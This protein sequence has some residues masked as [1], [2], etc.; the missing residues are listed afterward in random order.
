MSE[1]S[2]EKTILTPELMFNRIRVIKEIWSFLPS[3]CYR[4]KKAD[5]QRIPAQ[6]KQPN[7][8]SAPTWRN[9]FSGMFATPH[10]TLNDNYWDK[11]IPSPRLFK[12]F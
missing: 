10:S 12:I 5:I 4:E 11:T 7:V 9:R 3:I 8:L 1:T 2:A 6:P